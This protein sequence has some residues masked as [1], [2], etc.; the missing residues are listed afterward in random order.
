MKCSLALISQLVYGFACILYI[1]PN[2]NDFI[3]NLSL[4]NSQIHVFFLLKFML[5]LTGNI[6]M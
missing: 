1:L 3:I 4:Y 5:T 6:S 2:D